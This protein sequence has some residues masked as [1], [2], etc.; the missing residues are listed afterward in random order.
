MG[1]VMVFLTRFPKSTYNI[2]VIKF[3][4]QYWIW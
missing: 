3:N 1:L 2:P 4:L